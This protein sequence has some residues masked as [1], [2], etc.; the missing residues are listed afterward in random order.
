MYLFRKRDRRLMEQTAR[1]VALTLQRDYFA[2]SGK[3][4]TELSNRVP[5]YTGYLSTGAN[6]YP[7]IL[8]TAGSEVAAAFS[9]LQQLLT[10]LSLGTYQNW[11]SSAP[12][13]PAIWPVQSINWPWIRALYAFINPAYASHATTNNFPLPAGTNSWKTAWNS[14]P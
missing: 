13:N 1:D 6:A 8:W 12:K 14:A 10:Q 7:N 9:V 2:F 11:P 5:I 4:T 3:K